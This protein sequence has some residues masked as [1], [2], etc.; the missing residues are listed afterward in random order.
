MFDGNYRGID[1]PVLSELFEQAQHR[2][3]FEVGVYLVVEE[4]ILKDDFAA[5]Q[6][7]SVLN[8]LKCDEPSWCLSVSIGS[9]AG[10]SLV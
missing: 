3:L 5:V 7:R 8:S 10:N 9:E 4:C 2:R 6:F 1:S